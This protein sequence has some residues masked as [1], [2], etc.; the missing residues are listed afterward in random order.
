MPNISNKVGEDER[1]VVADVARPLAQW[2]VPP[3]AARYGRLLLCPNSVGL[4]QITEDLGIGK[5]SARMAARLLESS[6]L[7]RR[8]HAPGGRSMKWASF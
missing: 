7:S 3:V 2:G 4:D 8:H 1:R 6:T 5:S